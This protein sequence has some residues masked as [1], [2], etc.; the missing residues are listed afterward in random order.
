[1]AEAERQLGRDA[2]LATVRLGTIGSVA[3]APS[4]APRAAAMV[5]MSAIGFMEPSVARLVININH[6]FDASIN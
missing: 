5:S 1:M 2:E 3:G 4:T 6:V